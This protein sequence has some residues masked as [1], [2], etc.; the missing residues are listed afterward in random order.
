MQTSRDAICTG[1]CAAEDGQ[2]GKGCLFCSIFLKIQCQ[3]KWYSIQCSIILS[4][5]PPF[6]IGAV[7]ISVMCSPLPH[8][9]LQEVPS[10]SHGVYVQRPAHQR[11]FS[12]FH[13]LCFEK[14]SKAEQRKTQQNSPSSTASTASFH[15][16]NAWDIYVQ[17][18]PCSRGSLQTFAPAIH[19]CSFGVCFPKLFG[20]FVACKCAC[21]VVKSALIPVHFCPIWADPPLRAPL[22]LLTLHYSFSLLAAKNALMHSL[23]GSAL[24]TITLDTHLVEFDSDNTLTLVRLMIQYFISSNKLNNI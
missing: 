7:L 16:Q 18:Q 23:V 8:V 9:A 4:L 21:G 19:V 2:E 3:Q 14:Q 22:Q 1:C 13:P 10:C 12:L 24:L 11:C 6:S 20:C 15:Q 5:V 17:I